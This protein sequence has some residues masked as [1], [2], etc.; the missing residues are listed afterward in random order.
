MENNAFS[1]GDALIIMKRG[2]KLARHGWNGQGMHIEIQN[3]DAN[4]KMQSPYVFMRSLGG[5]LVPWV[6]SQTD[7][8]SEDWFEIK[9][10]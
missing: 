2:G 5:N 3:P 9:T 8:L 4:S 10:P 1:F 7:L 6:A